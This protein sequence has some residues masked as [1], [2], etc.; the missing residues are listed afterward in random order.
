MM[1][2]K[3]LALLA[4][5]AMLGG[6]S[7]ANAMEPL[8]NVQMDAVS[9]GW[10]SAAADAS[11]TALVSDNPILALFQKSFSK[12]NTTA[13]VVFG[14]GSQSSSSSRAS[15]KPFNPLDGNGDDD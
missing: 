5:V 2:T 7:A 14:L 10:G 8:S 13:D 1:R 9:A 3:F 4:G 12:T 11:A 6:V 15:I